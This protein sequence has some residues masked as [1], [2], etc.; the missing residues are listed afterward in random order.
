MSGVPA[1]VWGP[2]GISSRKPPWAS[3]TFTYAPSNEIRSSGSR[4]LASLT[5]NTTIGAVW[6]PASSRPSIRSQRAGRERQP[7]EA[8]RCGGARVVG[9][10]PVDHPTG[11]RARGHRRGPH[12]GGHAVEHRLRNVV[13]ELDRA[14]RAGE[15]GLEVGRDELRERLRVD[16]LRLQ[17]R[18]RVR[19]AQVFAEP[20]PGVVQ[21]VLRPGLTEVDRSD[22]EVA[23]LESGRGN[24]P[25]HRI[26]ELV[27][28]VREQRV[29][30][31]GHE[32]EHGLH[33]SIRPG[34]IGAVELHLPVHAGE[35]ARDRGGR[36]SAGS[37]C[38]SRD[39][40]V[41][42]MTSSGQAIV[43]LRD[44]RHAPTPRRTHARRARR[45][46]SRSAPR[47]PRSSASSSARRSR[48][49]TSHRRTTRAARRG[50]SAVLRSNRSHSVMVMHTNT[51]I[52]TNSTG[53]CW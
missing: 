1:E 16:R 5:W 3:W 18:H 32:V 28:G 30:V 25:V 21:D 19:L 33:R 34:L 42:T 52:M 13:A 37:S 12:V 10:A 27:V 22:E 40:N 41:S 26:E 53:R 20:L 2:A 31:A 4:R 51:A 11:R 6:G 49:G 9:R 7:V 47:S 43:V 39:T 15:H 50:R 17:E 45:R 44:P 38:R 35:A 29:E 46:S 36:R 14:R 48:A 23:L 24:A 8:H